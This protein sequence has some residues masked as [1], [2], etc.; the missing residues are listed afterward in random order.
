[1]KTNG[2]RRDIGFACTLITFPFL[3]FYF[4]CCLYSTSTLL[5]RLLFGPTPR[6]VSLI[7]SNCLQSIPCCTFCVPVRCGIHDSSGGQVPP[8]T[9]PACLTSMK[10]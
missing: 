10:S 2:R 6:E 5:T 9:Y 8:R 3:F 7:Q 1:V 4:C